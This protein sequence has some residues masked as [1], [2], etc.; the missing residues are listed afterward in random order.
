MFETIGIFAIIGGI[1]AAIAYYI[2]STKKSQRYYQA[3]ADVMQIVEIIENYHKAYGEYLIVER[4]IDE[5]PGSILMNILAAVHTPL[6]YPFYSGVAEHNPKMI[7]FAEVIMGRR[8]VNDM[9]VD[10]WD[11]P[12]HIAIDT[13]GDGIVELVWKTF[14]H[15]YEP[16][17][18]LVL[19]IYRPVIAWSNGPDKRNNLGFGDDICSWHS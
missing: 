4:N 9:I 14:T 5:Q 17:D 2:E 8:T 11:E 1:I 16:I 19:R 15:D 10:P 18:D 13:N 7:N 12:Y 3:R 6:G